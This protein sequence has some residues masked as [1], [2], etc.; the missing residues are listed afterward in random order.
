MLKTFAIGEPFDVTLACLSIVRQCKQDAHGSLAVDAAQI[1]RR[2]GLP[3]ELFHKP[4]SRMTASCG[5]PAEGLARALSIRVSISGSTGASWL[6]RNSRNRNAAAIS[7]TGS[8]STKWCSCCLSG[9]D[10]SPS[11]HRIEKWRAPGAAGGGALA[12][13]HR[14]HPTQQ[15]VVRRVTHST[16][17]GRASLEARPLFAQSMLTGK[18]L[19]AYLAHVVL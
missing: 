13:R 1:G 11:S 19:E 2:G 12:P 14:L 3:D 8:W 16:P 4:N 10:G 6:N 5:M 18:R 9:I 17:C 7:D 15:A